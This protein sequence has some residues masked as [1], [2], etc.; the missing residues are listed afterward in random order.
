MAR[1]VAGFGV[2]LL[3]V[4]VVLALGVTGASGRSLATT[5][6]LVQV[7]GHGTVT[8][9]G[10]TIN[11]GDGA[12][13]CYFTTS[14]TSGSVTLTAT[15]DS[16]WTFSPGW[17]QACGGTST[18]ELTLDGSNYEATATFS[19]TPLPGTSTLSVEVTGD[20]ADKG[21][22][23]KGGG[24]NCDP[25]DSD[26]TWEVT[27]GSTVTLLQAADPGYAFTGWGGVCAGTDTSC[28]VSMDADKSVNAAF[29]ASAA[30]FTLTVSVSGD[31]TVTGG[32]IGCTSAGGAGC[33]ASQGA[34][35]NVTLTAT[36]G[37]GASF[38]G[39]GGACA[40][41]ALTCTVTMDAAK[42][43]TATFSGAGGGTG[44]TFPLSVSVT[45]SGQVTGGGVSCGNGASACTVNVVANT[46]VTL[47]AAPASGATFTSWGGACSGSV[48]TCTLTMNA[49]KNVSATF[50]GATPPPGNELALT[51]VVRGKGTVTA[52]GGAC[53]S[54]GPARSCKQSYGAGSSI[55]LTAAPAAG[56]KFLGWGGSCRGTA[57][58]CRIE[59]SVSATVEATFSGATAG[60]GSALAARGRPIVRRGK[61]GFAVTLRFRA[62][63]SGTARIRA[64]RAGRIE[65]ALAFSVGPGPGS[66]GPLL[67]QKPGFYRFDL[68]LGARAIEWRACLGRCGEGAPGGP[69]TVVREPT[70]I[71]R[72]GEAWSVTV[73]FR[74]NRLSGAELRIS[75]AR[76]LVTDV[77]F[78]PPVG[79]V[80]AGPFVLTPGVY[81]LRLT[82]TDA[83]GRTRRLS[84][85]A[86]LPE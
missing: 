70:V 54:S 79:E 32:G 61:G 38:T 17:S 6:I 24:I 57:T 69:F 9:T 39:W 4:V 42:S 74:T 22:T 50:S 77:R 86:Y 49:A 60:T 58:A 48:T 30:N 62:G 37:S 35:S 53:S 2:G 12:T 76:R 18:C 51:V 7:I 68:R 19:T 71:V 63:Q 10:G 40:G 16:G 82:V 28:T 64:I 26:C 23:V 75:R 46:S 25:S 5:T 73:R 3:V 78:A 84:W 81:T 43:V 31:G 21:G 66:V 20:S 13:L 27:T 56:A 55:E 34:N 1:R 67:V 11:C 47:T 44:S 36:P 83:Y 14:A 85:F 29:A 52:S 15:A 45:G 72:A 65:T 80:R 8:G 41:S 59:L 33:S